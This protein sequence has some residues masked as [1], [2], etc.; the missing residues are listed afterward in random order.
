MGTKSCGMSRTMDKGV[1]AA[2]KRRKN[3]H[4]QLDPITQRI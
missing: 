3:N 4:G 2:K 1:K